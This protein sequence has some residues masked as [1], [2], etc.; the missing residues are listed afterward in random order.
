MMGLGNQ[1][2]GEA[3]APSIPGVLVEG[4]RGGISCSGQ[5]TRRVRPAR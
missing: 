2:V 5:G 4:A 3:R 1:T